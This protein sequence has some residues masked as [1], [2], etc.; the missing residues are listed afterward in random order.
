MQEI[1]NYSKTL[2]NYLCYIKKNK[3]HVSVQHIK[4]FLTG[5][6][7]AGKTNFRHLLLNSPFS[8]HQASTDVLETRLAYAVQ[9]SASLLQSKEGNMIWYQ[10][11]PNQQLIYFKSLLDQGCHAEN[12]KANP[13]TKNY[14]SDSSIGESTSTD[15][16]IIVDTPFDPSVLEE[17]VLQSDKLPEYLCIGNT[18]KIITIIDTGGQP[19]YIHLLPAIVNSP[20]IN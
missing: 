12:Y 5:S 16:N 4:I 18:I 11:T 20:T 17:K 7:A 14:R 6:A 19:G 2:Y 15:E 9:N 8:E 3:V 1:K 13:H 10:F